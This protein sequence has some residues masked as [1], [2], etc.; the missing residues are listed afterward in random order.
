MQSVGRVMRKS[1]G[2]QYGYII[3]PIGIPADLTPE[4]ALKDNQ[5]Y[6]V[7]WQVLQALRAHD[8]R[9][10][11]TVNKIELNNA[12][13]PQIDVI[14][15]GGGSGDD[16]GTGESDKISP[17]QMELNFP[18]LEEWRDAIYAKIVVK[19]GDRRYWESWAKDVATIAERHTTRIKALLDDPALQHRAAFNDFLTGLQ[20]NV[21]PSVSEADA[22]EMLSQHQITKPVFDALFEGDRFTQQNPVSISMQKMLNLL[23][24]QSLEKDIKSLDKFYSSVR[25]RA[26]GIDNAEGKQR[27]IVELYD[28]FF[29]T[30]F[31]RMAK[32]LGIVY[33][34]VEVVDF[35]IKS[36]DDAL[37]QEFG[38]GLSD[39]NVHVLDPFTGTGTF[40]VR[41]L[42]SGLIKP[43]DLSRKFNQ[44]LHANEI[45]LLAYYIAAVN[46]EAAYH[47]AIGGDYLPFDGI[48]LTD[49]FQMFESEGTLDKL[50]FPENNERV[51]R[52]KQNDIRVIIGNPPYE[53]GQES[54]NDNNQ[55]IK[56]AQLDQR[57]SSTYIENSS[58]KEGKSKSYASE[59]RALR[60]A[61]DRI[62]DKGIVCYISNGSFIDSMSNDGL[63][64]CLT[65][66]FTSVYC[67]NLRGNQRTSG[68]TS[69]QEGG[70]I[71]GSGSRATI[72]IT[73]LIKNPEKSGQHQLFYHDIGDYLSREEKLDKIKNFGSFTS[74]DWDSIIP[75]K[76]NDWI[77]Q[78]N[79]EFD[80]FILLGDKKD[81][82]IKTVF[83]IFSMG[84]K[85]NRDTWVYNFS[86]VNSRENM[87]QMIDFYNQQSTSYSELTSDRRPEISEFINYDP[88]RIKWTEDIIKDAAKGVQHLFEIGCIR[89]GIYRPFCKQFLYYS[90]VFNWTHHLIP[91]ILPNDSLNNLVICVTGMGVVKDFSALIV[92]VVPDV[93]LQANGQCFPLY[94]YEKSEPTTLFLAETGYTKKENIPDTILSDFQTTYQDQAITKE[95]IFY[96]IYG[97]LH[98]PEYKHRFAADLKKMLPKIPYAQDFG[99]FSNAGRKLAQ[100]HLNYETI[101]PYPLDEIKAELFLNEEDYRVS[102]MTFERRNKAI[103]K[104]TIVYNSKIKLIGIPLEAYEYIV[105][106]KPALEWI[107]E[108]YQL[109]KDKDSGITNDPND[110]SDEPRY[111][112]DLVKRIVRVSL[113]TVKIVD[114]LPALNELR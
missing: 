27:I 70:K 58:K 60:W 46:I 1:E 16:E 85:T 93:Q 9:F 5:K 66:E 11:A 83:E 91:L 17:V 62:K 40:I 19:C 81:K 112:I 41:M 100:W 73:L 3:L 111:I 33:T 2:K 53:S 18:H 55:N 28:K 34:P 106:G 105:N 74:I 98:S 36:A 50:M 108:R 56:Y 86:E 52:Q 84:V 65:D 69:R 20:C 44:E 31:P 49:T 26:S 4:E 101:E 21:N 30:A 54:A 76:N 22:I 32:R 94:T 75:N 35:I 12:K 68:E 51:N 13:P 95:D 10:N 7:V 97:I 64:K 23:E 87:E 71:F 6:K 79:P 42:Q 88:K 45:V 38:A 43:E 57:I 63:R 103:D 89:K 113:E 48:V 99:A 110:W 47:S 39:E 78:R 109:T 104:T 29:R 8:D 77:N 96:Y 67:F 102:K 37:K 15:I 14:G 82:T 24:G 107:M 90:K 59:I 25:E 80:V 92:D 61:S 72:T 114:D